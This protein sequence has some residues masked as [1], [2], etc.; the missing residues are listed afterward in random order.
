MGPFPVASDKN[1]GPLAGATPDPVYGNT[2]QRFNVYRP[3]DL[4]QGGYCHPIILW[5][6]GHTDNP[7]PNP[8]DCV[9]S[10]YCGSYK[11]I[12]DQ[13]ALA[14]VRG[15]GVPQHDRVPARP[16]HRPLA[17]ARGH[18]LDPPAS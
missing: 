17:A 4:S 2:Q 18:E 1:V 16:G 6:N 5:G 3:A 8:P 11:T 9:S 12:I 15:G 14:G 10:K 13:L 7:E